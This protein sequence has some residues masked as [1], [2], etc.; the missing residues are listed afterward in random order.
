MIY[1]TAGRL[2]RGA[3]RE[4]GAPI[5]STQ[6]TGAGT[7]TYGTSTKSQTEPFALYVND[8][9]DG[10]VLA[11]PNG[12]ES[13][14]RGSLSAFDAKNGKLMWRTYMTPD[15][16]QLPYILTWA[17]PAEAAVGGAPIW[18]IPTYDIKDRLVIQGT[19]NMYPYLGAGSP[20]R[21]CGRTAS[22]RSTSTRVR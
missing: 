14:M 12:G 7:G 9:K 22:S 3:E 19:G 13:P 17:N 10:L 1:S 2:D 6:V 21:T 18:S 20:A 5:W 15:A 16:T 11:A 8:G 4:D